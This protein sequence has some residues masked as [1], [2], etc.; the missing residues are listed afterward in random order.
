M[1]KV[2]LITGSSGSGKTTLATSLTKRPFSNKS[3]CLL[4]M[5][6]FYKSKPKDIPAENYDFDHPDAIDWNEFQYVVHELYSGR[7]VTICTY[8]FETHMKTD[9][10]IELIAADILLI[11][12]N[13]VAHN[14]DIR[15]IATR[16]IFVSTS[17]D[18][19]LC[20]KITRDIKERG[21]TT[22]G[23]IKQWRTQVKPGYD[24]FIKPVKKYD[25]VIIFKNN[26]DVS[27]MFGSKK[28]NELIDLIDE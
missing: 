5:D 8:S 14:P 11:E 17:L 18:E 21:R 9:V 19:C 27:Q 4:S 1:V 13:L 10:A 15:K 25:N 28:Y 6:H 22:S 2:F 20:R 24:A 3:T 16:I 12:G 23:S 26:S 7:N